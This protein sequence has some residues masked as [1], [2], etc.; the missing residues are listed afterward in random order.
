MWS[1]AFPASN[2]FVSVYYWRKPQEKQAH[3]WGQ[4]VHGASA[5]YCAYDVCSE[6]IQ[7]SVCTYC[8]I[9]ASE[10]QVS[11]RRRPRSRSK[12]HLCV[13]VCVCVFVCVCVHANWHYCRLPGNTSYTIGAQ[14]SI[15]VARRSLVL[16]GNGPG[17][18]ILLPMLSPLR[19][20][21][22]MFPLPEI[23]SC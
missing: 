6:T 14:T 7:V 10:N 2:S 1:C 3:C 9:T 19:M 21:T 8:P 18:L 20:W 13:C 16:L 5:Y 12:L 15:E 23:W 4:K 22:M 17:R 11:A